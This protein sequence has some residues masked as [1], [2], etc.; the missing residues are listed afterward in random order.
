MIRRR[1]DSE[2]DSELV[3]EANIDALAGPTHHYGGLGVG[4][5][6]SYEHG[7]TSSSPKA[8]ALEGLQK[9]A[10]VASLG[11]PQFIWLPPLRPRFEFLEAIG[12]GGQK[13]QQLQSA[14]VEAPAALSAAYSS[15]FMWAA[16]SGVFSSSCDTND[17]CCHFT[18]ANLIS[19]W[20]RA[21]ESEERPEDLA[22]MFHGTAAQLVVHPPLPAIVPLRDEGA[23]NYMRLCG[24][25][26][27]DAIHLFVYGDHPQGPSQFMPRQTR[28]SVEAIARRHRLPVENTFFLQQHPSAIDAG[29]F[30][31]DVIATS[32]GNLLV[33]HELAFRDG[34]ET[35]NQVADR[36]R[37]VCGDELE[38]LKICSRELSLE[39]AVKSYLFNSQILAIPGS[40]NGK[41]IVCPTN[42]QKIPTAKQVVE[43]MVE[44]SACSV[45]RAEFVSLHQS[46]SG[47][48]GPAC[49][50]LRV[51]LSSS[52]LQQGWGRAARLTPSL[53]EALGE[54]VERFYPDRLDFQEL[55]L[56]ETAEMAERATNELRRVAAAAQLGN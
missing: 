46:M 18:P 25:S 10:M 44:N 35:L 50:R 56:L 22:A 11:V 23:A 49:V 15:A 33:H 47:G 41:S 14:Y 55:R 8:A 9:A 38:I 30:H 17:G 3:V 12:F 40:E 51:P 31:N 5:L 26:G 53:H 19:S 24:Q 48:G 21:F 29:V 42:C 32:C 45:Q 2:R 39:D 54:V 34:E 36:F 43:R 16:N 6:A 37:V 52:V 4:N 27:W 7:F 1:D 20:H 13:A 28:A